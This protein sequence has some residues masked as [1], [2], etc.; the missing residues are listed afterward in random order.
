MGMGGDLN[1]TA[2]RNCYFCLSEALRF[3]RMG[4]GACVPTTFCNTAIFFSNYNVKLFDA[5]SRAS[6]GYAC[7]GGTSVLPVLCSLEELV[8]Y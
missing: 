5:H 2:T 4:Y 6:C 8:Y 7:C 1:L 3:L